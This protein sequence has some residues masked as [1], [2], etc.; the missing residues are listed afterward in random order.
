MGISKRKL[1]LAGA[2]LPILTVGF[3]VFERTGV[4]DHIRGLNL[5]EGAAMRFD[6]SYAP[7][8]SRPVRVGDPEWI[9][10]LE[11]ISKYSHVDLPHEKE[12]RVIARYTAIA[13]ARVQ[14]GPDRIS[15]WTAPGTPLFL[16]YRDWPGNSVPP[17]DY[18]I[19][20]TIGDLHTW[21]AQS[22]ADFHSN[23]VDI[24]LALT[25][26]VLGLAVWRVSGM[27]DES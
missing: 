27:G 8:A 15:E 10:L 11:L 5:A 20:G 6:L 3:V 1:E 9:S 21:I 26:F 17:E 7:Q 13:D 12:P 16:L 23:V 14:I 4:W 2:L 19:I 18:R 25:S 22:K 24:L